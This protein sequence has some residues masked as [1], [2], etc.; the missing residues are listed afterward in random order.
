MG[1][2]KKDQCGACGGKGKIDV[3]NDGNSEDTGTHSET[4]PTCNG[5]GEK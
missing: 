5:S 2:G 1:H 3:P 4:C